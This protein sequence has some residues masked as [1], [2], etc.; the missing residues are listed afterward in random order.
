MS[1]VSGDGLYHALDWL[2][3]QLGSVQ[4]KKALVVPESKTPHELADHD[5][6]LEH[7][8]DYCSRAYTAIKCLFL[9]TNRQE[10]HEPS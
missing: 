5:D 6:A 9:R 4:A 10:G 3:S 1:A 7:G 8:V 2:A